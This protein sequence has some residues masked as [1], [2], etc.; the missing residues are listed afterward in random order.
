M[1][2]IPAARSIDR[3]TFIGTAAGAI[4]GTVVGAQA[5]IAA[6]S[7]ETPKP[8]PSDDAPLFHKLKFDG[9]KISDG[10][11][12]RVRQAGIRTIPVAGGKYN[13]WTRRVGHGPLKVLALHGGP[14]F[15]HEYLECLQDFLPNAGCELYLYDQLGC[16]NSDHPDDDTLWTVTRYLTEVEEVRSGLGLT[17]FVLFGHSWGGMLVQEYAVTYPNHLRAAVISNMTASMKSYV[18][19]IDELRKQLAP[20]I[21]AAMAKYE[22]ERKF[23]AP[24][25]QEILFTQL[26]KRH[27]CRLNPW[28]EPI[29]MSLAHLNQKIYK[30]MQGPSEFVITGNFRDWDRWADLHR[31]TTPT[32][33]LAARYDTMSVDDLRKMGSLIPHSRV[34]VCEEGSHL[35][36]YDEQ[37]TYFHHLLRFLNDV[38]AGRSIRT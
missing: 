1:N 27:L 11:P 36:M 35:A 2:A 24:E 15:T 32:L 7:S 33:I 34:A 22:A 20:S 6:A 26:Y 18:A 31:I 21:Q 38:R 23:D 25:Y 28:P 8:A 17:D 29:E 3:R 30:Q 5:L 16:G 37:P 14:G 10:P 12:V 4:A 9:E 13:V 19:H